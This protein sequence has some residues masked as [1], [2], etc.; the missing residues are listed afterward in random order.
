MLTD[1]RTAPI[2][3]K[4]KV[5]LAF[6]EK[7]TLRPEDVVPDDV[8]PLRAAG[9]SDRA[10]SDAIH[11]CAAFNAIDRIADA[12]A[13]AIPSPEAFDKAADF[14]LSKGYDL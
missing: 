3:D 7:L 13:F 8:A 5:T 12:F 4:L 2:S 9:I 10:I 6:L 11:V 1:Y 14:L